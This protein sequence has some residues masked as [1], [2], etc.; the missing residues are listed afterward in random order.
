MVPL[1]RR[2]FKVVLFIGLFLLSVRYVH[3]YP[4]PMTESQL[5]FWFSVSERFGIR[6]PEDLYVPVMVIIELIVTIFAYIIIIRLWR[7]YWAKR[8]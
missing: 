4:L 6:D 8:A 2:F 1:V 5:D 3:T 7:H